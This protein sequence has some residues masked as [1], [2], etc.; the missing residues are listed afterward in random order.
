MVDV[1]VIRKPAHTL[2]R[3]DA[4]ALKHP[5]NTPP[6]DG[7][8][9]LAPDAEPPW[10][11]VTDIDYW[12]DNEDH[13]WVESDDYPWDSSHIRLGLSREREPEWGPEV[14]TD[15]LEIDWRGPGLGEYTCVWV[16]SVYPESHAATAAVPT[17]LGRP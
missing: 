5:G 17:P 16:A 12:R 15:F 9:L 1:H 3:G 13:K 2:S 7:R 4:V 8:L 6:P 14:W 10:W 11:Y